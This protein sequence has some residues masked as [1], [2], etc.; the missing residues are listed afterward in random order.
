[1]PLTMP[2][3]IPESNR[4]KLLSVPF[5]VTLNT[6]FFGTESKGFVRRATAQTDIPESAKVVYVYLDH[7]RNSFCFVLEDE[8]FPKI[9]NGSIPEE[10]KIDW[11]SVRL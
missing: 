10:I 2:L 8:S 7:A 1:M 4:R 5:E 6:L 3:N 11:Q 9:Q